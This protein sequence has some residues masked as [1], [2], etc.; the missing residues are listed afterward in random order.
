M[1][2]A[3]PPIDLLSSVHAAAVENDVGLD[4]HIAATEIGPGGS[5]AWRTFTDACS[6][7]APHLLYNIQLGGV[8]VHALA[9]GGGAKPSQVEALSSVASVANIA[10]LD[11]Y[12]LVT[13][14]RAPGEAGNPEAWMSRAL[15]VPYVLTALV[16]PDGTSADDAARAQAALAFLRSPP[17]T[18]G[19]PSPLDT[20]WARMRAGERARL[21][22]AADEA[23]PAPRGD[24]GLPMITQIVDEG[25][26]EATRNDAAQLEYGLSAIMLDRRAGG[27]AVITR[28]GT[29][30]ARGTLLFN[31]R[32]VGFAKMPLDAASTMTWPA[33]IL[34]RTGLGP[35]V[36]QNFFRIRTARHLRKD[37]KTQ[38][39]GSMEVWMTGE[40]LDPFVRMLVVAPPGD[41][42]GLA[43]L[44]YCGV[45]LMGQRSGLD[46]AVTQLLGATGGGSGGGDGSGVVAGFTLEP[47]A[48]GV[49]T[50]GAAG[51]A[52]LAISS[53][54]RKSLLPGAYAE[55]LLELLLARVPWIFSLLFDLARCRGVA[56]A[57]LEFYSRAADG[58]G[59]V[60]AELIDPLGI[61]SNGALL[62][63][64]RDMAGGAPLPDVLAVAVA[65]HYGVLSVGQAYSE[66]DVKVFKMVAGEGFTTADSQLLHHD[67]PERLD[68]L[69]A[70]GPSSRCGLVDP[71]RAG[72]FSRTA[73][74]DPD[75]TVDT[76]CQ[77]VYCYLCIHVK[78]H[79]LP[80]EAPSC[81]EG[82]KAGVRGPSGV[83]F[84]EQL[85]PSQAA[86]SSAPPHELGGAGC[87][88][89][90]A[91][92]G[93]RGGEACE[94][95]EVAAEVPRRKQQIAPVPV[96]GIG[97]H[98][99][100]AEHARGDGA[101]AT[102]E[103]R[104]KAAR[105]A[106]KRYAASLMIGTAHKAKA[107]PETLGPVFYI[108]VPGAPEAA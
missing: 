12:A 31:L 47:L 102:E 72:L 95:G 64:L 21:G 40:A 65:M 41:A 33:M 107:T 82:C 60:Q 58:Y 7:D 68:L 99:P 4:I 23:D 25:D 18:P 26:W 96:Q 54:L 39:G 97:D 14:A 5:R 20:A 101:P 11:N 49:G 17:G 94:G 43:T 77:H 76:L 50:R 87:G 32:P 79:H 24:G 9:G 29:T 35:V 108:G 6:V 46:L 63:T 3:P 42:T 13:T 92:P 53:W 37:R 59:D 80:P 10:L 8:L 84:F 71:P 57:L 104:G 38:V 22:L 1:A 103:P 74:G 100:A 52:N 55:L 88:G 36:G 83:R 56:I 27:E 93:G 48:A 78:R 90:V 106:A 61:R 67:H 45:G 44:H 62:Q 34:Q 30:G 2:H 28:P 66:L 75:E 69:G 105:L 51:A 16:Q 85:T 81:P 98:R 19:T 70:N 73:P 86:P 91:R 15:L 89:P